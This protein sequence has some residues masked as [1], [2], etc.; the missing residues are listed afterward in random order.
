LIG[1][2]LLTWALLLAGVLLLARWLRTQDTQPH[3]RVAGLIGG[4][5]LLSHLLDFGAILALDPGLID[6]SS[7]LWL[8]VRDHLGAP[9]ALI[10]G[11]TGKLLIALLSHQLYLTYRLQRVAL[12]PTARIT[13]HRDFYQAFGGTHTANLLNLLSFTVP[14]LSPLLLCVLALELTE[15]HN[16]LSVQPTLPS[17]VVGWLL[18]LPVLY[19]QVSHRAHLATSSSHPSGS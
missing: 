19:F 8:A 3:R 14:L 17:V 4:L 18:L 7:P 6:N 15:S 10:Y 13:S 2:A 11:L 16:W 1:L 5:A 12:F 9:T